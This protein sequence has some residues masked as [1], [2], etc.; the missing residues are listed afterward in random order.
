VQP[1]TP[2]AAPA[3]QAAS[4]FS[5]QLRADAETILV[6]AG[7]ISKAMTDS[8]DPT[9][10][11]NV[12]VGVMIGAYF[13]AAGKMMGVVA[14]TYKGLAA[15]SSTVA[16]AQKAPLVQ[17]AKV[18]A[19]ESETMAGEATQTATA[20]DSAGGATGGT[21]AG[22]WPWGS[23]VPVGSGAGVGYLEDAVIE[24]T[25]SGLPAQN[26]SVKTCAVLSCARLAQILEHNEPTMQ[27]IDKVMQTMRWTTTTAANGAVTRAMA[28]LK[29]GQV[30]A[31][32]Q[33]VGINA[34]VGTT[35]E[36]LLAQAK[37]GN[38]VIAGVYTTA[39]QGAARLHAVVIEG[40]ETRGE[41]EGI[42]AYD[43]TGYDYWQPVK[44][45]SKYFDN[46]F[47]HPL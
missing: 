24:E 13:G 23:G 11:N 15:A 30:V 9:K 5:D 40:L 7:K 43:P 44:T 2:G 1:T 33:K 47:V 27:V 29:P 31:A 39:T 38:P 19:T 41:V 16:A 28:G 34:Q 17:I 4:E 10:H 21:A 22:A 36:K 45:F 20:L 3:L 42:K 35:M 46:T 12:G 8:M 32:L 25:T 26:V 18:A 37:A 6:S 14:N